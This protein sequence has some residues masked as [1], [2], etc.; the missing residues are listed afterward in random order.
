MIQGPR[1][2]FAKDIRQLI[3]EIDKACDVV[4]WFDLLYEK[5]TVYLNMLS[6]LMKSGF[7]YGNMQSCFIITY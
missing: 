5:M 6:P 3:I 7:I 4:V 2:N 1:K